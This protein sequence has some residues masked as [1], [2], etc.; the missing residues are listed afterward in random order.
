[1]S[2]CRRVGAAVTCSTNWWAFSGSRCTVVWA[3]YED[4]ND[5]ERF[6]RR[7]DDAGSRWTA[8]WS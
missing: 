3:G 6:G 7:S 2:V 8:R 1:M 5:A 4:T